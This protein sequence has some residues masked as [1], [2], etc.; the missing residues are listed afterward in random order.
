MRQYNDFSSDTQMLVNMNHFL[1]LWSSL[2]TNITKLELFSCV[3]LWP[4]FKKKSFEV[5][6]NC[7]HQVD[8]ISLESWTQ[9]VALKFLAIWLNFG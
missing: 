4:S 1:C 8:S 6:M 9:N 5:N 2:I 7:D 3:P